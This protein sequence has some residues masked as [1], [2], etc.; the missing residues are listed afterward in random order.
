MWS[1][2]IIALIAGL[3][4]IITAVSSFRNGGK[5]KSLTTGQMVAS[6]DRR[7]QTGKIIQAVNGGKS[8][9]NGGVIGDS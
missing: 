8:A 5:L 2:I 9:K 4:G 7:A 3:P 6:Q 1:N